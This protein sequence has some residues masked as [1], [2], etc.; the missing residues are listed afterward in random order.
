[1][2]DIFDEVRE[3]RRDNMQAAWDKYGRYIIGA[4]V[5]LVVLVAAVIGTTSVI[6]NARSG[7]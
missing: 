3:P 7:L 2:S 6:D 4:A 5:G 1:M